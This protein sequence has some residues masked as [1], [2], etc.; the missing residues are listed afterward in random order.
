MGKEDWRE[1]LVKEMCELEEKIKRLC[2]F[3]EEVDVFQTLSCTQ[4]QLLVKQL[5]TMKEYSAILSLRLYLE[6]DEQ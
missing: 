5:M 6:G 2:F 3:I 4:R 1:R